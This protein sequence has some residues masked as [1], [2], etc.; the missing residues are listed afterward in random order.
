MSKHTH[1][2]VLC[3]FPKNEHTGASV[4]LWV[5]SHHS[6]WETWSCSVDSQPPEIPSTLSHCITEC[7]SRCLQTRPVKHWASCSPHPDSKQAS[8]GNLTSCAMYYLIPAVAFT[9]VLSNQKPVSPLK[10]S[11]QLR[12]GCS[13]ISRFF[14]ESYAVHN[15]FQQVFLDCFTILTVQFAL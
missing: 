1:K 5:I 8:T 14:T 9:H 2:S 3:S 13:K 4:S 7:T 6:V 10:M 15:S 12:K 11:N